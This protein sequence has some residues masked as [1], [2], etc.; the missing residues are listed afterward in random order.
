MTLRKGSVFGFSGFGP[1]FGPFLSEQVVS[2]GLLEGFKRVWDSILVEEPRFKWIQSSTCQVWSCSKIVIFGFDP[3]LFLIWFLCSF[4]FANQNLMFT[5]HWPDFF[6][7]QILCIYI[8]HISRYYLFNIWHFY[9]SKSKCSR[10][11]RNGKRAVKD[12]VGKNNNNKTKSLS[13]KNL[14]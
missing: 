14:L 13:R 6:S 5:G 2:S 8:I 4:W 11:S 1:E 9:F 10:K 7:H 3:T 12:V